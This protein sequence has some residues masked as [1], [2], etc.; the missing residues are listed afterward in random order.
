MYERAVEELIRAKKAYYAG[1]PIVDDREFDM[2]EDELRRVD[3]TNDYFT[4]VGAPVEDTQG[5][6]IKHETKLKSMDKGKTPGDVKKWL[7]KIGME[8]GD[9]IC[10]P[11]IDGLAATCHYEDGELIFVATRGD[12]VVGKDITHIAKY[13]NDIPE[14]IDFTKDEID[15]RGEIYL[16]KWT[17][18]DTKGKSLRNNAVGLVNR[19]SDKSETHHLRFV[20]YKV[21][22]EEFDNT[23]E[24][25]DVLD[26][27]SFNTVGPEVTNS[28]KEIYTDY[29]TY[30][31]D[32]YEYETDGLVFV[33]NDTTKYQRIN[34]RYKENDHHDF[35]NFALKPPAEEKQT[36]LIGITWQMSRQGNLI[37][38]ANFKP[39]DIGGASIEK[40]TLNNYEN[41]RDLNLKK[42][43]N[44]IISR[45]NDVIPFFKETLG[46]GTGSALDLIPMFCP[47]CGSTLQEKG[48]HLHCPNANC[49]EQMI[50]KIIYWVKEA[51]IDNVAEGM[52]RLIYKNTHLT[53][54][55]D[56][57]T[58]EEKD[59]L[60]IE[61]L[62]DRKIGMFLEG[63]KK[64][65]KISTTDLLSRMNIELVRKKALKKLNINTIQ[66][67]LDFND[68][69]SA[70]GRN[71]IEWKNSENNMKLL[72]KLQEI[73]YVYNVEEENKESKG[74]ICA[75]GS[76]PMK[77]AELVKQIEAKGYEWSSSV[78]KDL[79]I[80][81]V[82]NLDGTSSKLVKA[83]KNGIKIMLYE[84]FL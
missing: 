68:E 24:S 32:A 45:A 67:F 81:L 7:D 64:D 10:L 84:E 33:I 20:A 61:G 27:N 3:P 54:P 44:I 1:N 39:V 4:L 42:S 41:V 49:S 79:Q 34:A 55:A 36:Y 47:H 9:T 28:L 75:T 37:P 29:L 69:S 30:I 25:L 71:V 78:S 59:L 15:I 14:T 19:K 5:N 80:L 83:R 56:L 58:L 77:R 31:R 48:V 73:M 40:A 70:I 60:G 6:D 52:L 65:R 46:G 16:P 82:D 17:K 12:G 74:K 76:A 2:M 21:I 53:D 63:M 43:D 18:Y 66:E 26:Q 35:W 11:K 51:D 57:Y 38:V 8:L 50:Q 22:G 72:D 23:L 13:M 62:G